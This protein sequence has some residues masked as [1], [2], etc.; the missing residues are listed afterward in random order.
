MKE[1]PSGIRNLHKAQQNYKEMDFS[2][3]LSYGT[4][5]KGF[6]YKLCVVLDLDETLVHTT[7]FKQPCDFSFIVGG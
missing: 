3:Y 4:Q 7:S 6:Y 2:K 1:S 5:I